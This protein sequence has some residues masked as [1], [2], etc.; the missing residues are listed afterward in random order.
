VPSDD[1]ETLGRTDWPYAES[2]RLVP[3]IADAGR[4]LRP[5]GLVAA[6]EQAARDLIALHV[7][8]EMVARRLTGVA[9]PDLAADDLVKAMSLAGYIDLRDPESIIEQISREVDADISDPATWQVIE[10]IAGVLLANSRLERP[11][12]A[13]LL[14]G[15]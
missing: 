14:A 15:A 7:A 8:G 3:F 1:G 5:M 11:E 6:D 10:R 12:L 4:R 9:M 13:R 2:P